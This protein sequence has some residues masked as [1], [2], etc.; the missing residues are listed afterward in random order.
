LIHEQSN[1]HPPDDLSP[2]ESN[3]GK[4]LALIHRVLPRLDDP[5]RRAEVQSAL[6]KAVSLLEAAR[7]A[8]SRRRRQSDAHWLATGRHSRGAR[9]SRP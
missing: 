5:A 2:A 4:V 8:H 1:T 3:L 6:S 9:R 7:T